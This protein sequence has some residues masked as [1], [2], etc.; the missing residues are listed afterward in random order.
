MVAVP[1]RGEQFSELYL[2]T[3]EPDGGLFVDN[4]SQEFAIDHHPKL[5]VEIGNQDYE[6]TNYTVVVQFLEI[7]SKANSAVVGDRAEIDRL[8]TSVAH[9]ETYHERRIIAQSG[10]A[11]TS[12]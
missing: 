11:R 10:R 5:I 12:A 2:L 4:H 1:Q 7:R 6:V 9:N 8:R 3:E